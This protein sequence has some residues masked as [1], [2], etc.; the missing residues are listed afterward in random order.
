MEQRCGN[1]EPT[2]PRRSLARNEQK[3]K[4][5]AAAKETPTTQPTRNPANNTRETMNDDTDSEKAYTKTQQT[6]HNDPVDEG[7]TT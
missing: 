2:R 4:I 1:E 6:R 3:E 7:Q 5:T